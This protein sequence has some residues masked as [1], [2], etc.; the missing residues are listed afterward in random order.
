M[1]QLCGK[2]IDT[3]ERPDIA[4][5]VYVKSKAKVE[6]LR[7]QYS[8]TPKPLGEGSYGKV[9]KATNI[10]NEKMV[11]AIKTINKTQMSDEE[12]LALQSEVSLMQ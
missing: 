4:Q 6:D 7:K 3:L 2:P 11:I 8:I 10:K 1:G 12:L 5:N 9:F